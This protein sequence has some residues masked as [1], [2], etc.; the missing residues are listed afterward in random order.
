MVLVVRVA[1]VVVVVAAAAAAVGR[2]V[3]GAREHGHAH[4]C[5]TSSSRRVSATLI[6]VSILVVW[7]KYWMRVCECLSWEGGHCIPSNIHERI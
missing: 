2:Q 4:N 6:V 5:H 1:V 7:T 3:W